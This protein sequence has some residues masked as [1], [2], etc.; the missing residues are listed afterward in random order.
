MQVTETLKEGLKREIKVVIPATDL[1]AKLE[2]RLEDAKNKVQIKGFRPGKVPVQHIHKLYGRS[3][4]AEIINEILNETPQTILRERSERSATQPKVN[5]SEDEQQAEKVLSGNADFDFTLSY[6]I[7]PAID[8]KDTSNISITRHVVEIPNAEIE[9]Q[10]EKIFSSNRNFTTK[11][12][13][14]EDGDRVTMDFLGKIDGVAFDGGAAE[15]SPLVLGSN[16]FIPGFEDQLIGIKAGDE[17]V[18]TVTFPEDYNADHLAGKVATFD[19]KAKEVASAD[20][21]VIDDEA[22]KNLGIESLDRLR[23]IVREQMESQYGQMTRQTVKRQILDNLDQDYKFEA[24]SSLIEAEFNNI[25]HQITT[26][27]KQT[28][29]SFEQE[30]TT[31]QEA[32]AEYEKLAE[33][34]VRL[35]LVISAIGEKAKIEVTEDELQRAVYTQLQQYPGQ[36][37]EIMDFFRRTPDAVANLR[38]P[39][40]E[41]KTIDYL[42]GQINVTDQKVTPEELTA[43]TE[44]ETLSVSPKAKDSKKQ[45][46]K[47]K[48]VADTAEKPAAKKATKKQ[49]NDAEVAEKPKAASK[50]SAKKATAKE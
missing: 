23:E 3:F 18:I 24:P 48:E 22:A 29:S 50:A 6:E 25:W 9:Q 37:K 31:E 13:A 19:I 26:E 47:K 46:A 15:D 28:G 4:M 7:L 49:E 16:S 14:A 1:K 38:A 36:E 5:M 39:I 2:D 41:E 20:A 35:G 17:K 42:L 40:F 44:S 21:V 33:R 10:I 27:L 43:I 11:D 12:G 30:E 8:L 32:R 45:T 34:R